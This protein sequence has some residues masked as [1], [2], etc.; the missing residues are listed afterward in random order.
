MTEIYSA[1]LRR[2]RP[3]AFFF[4][5]HGLPASNMCLMVRA[6]NVRVQSPP[7]LCSL[8]VQRSA[9]CCGWEVCVCSEMQPLPCWLARKSVA[10]ALSK[11]ISLFISEH[12]KSQDGMK[13]MEGGGVYLSNHSSGSSGYRL[14]EALLCVCV[15]VLQLFFFVP[16]WCRSSC[17]PWRLE[18]G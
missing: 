7:H 3:S 11:H 2:V 5:L 13:G 16:S 10:P 12:H 14:C 8:G 9:H 18:T 6:G 1:R 4:W 17:R 15:C